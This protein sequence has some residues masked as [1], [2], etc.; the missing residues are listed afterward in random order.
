MGEAALNLGGRVISNLEFRDRLFDMPG[1]QTFK[2][3]L[4]FYADISPKIDH[5]VSKTI[6]SLDELIVK[7]EQMRTSDDPKSYDNLR[8]RGSQANHALSE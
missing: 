1:W 3:L 5:E 4:R 6:S 7:I 8:S 2:N